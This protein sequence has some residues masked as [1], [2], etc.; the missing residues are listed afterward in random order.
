MGRD[1]SL[2]LVD[3]QPLAVRVAEALWAAGAAEVLAIGGDAE[4]LRAWDLAVRPDDHPGGGPLPATVTALHVA[5]ESIVMV[6][7]CD[8]LAPSADAVAATVHALVA[9]PDVLSA[10][11]VVDG[12]RQWTHAAWRRP[13]GDALEAEWKSGT[14]ALHRAAALLALVEVADLDPLALVDADVPGDLP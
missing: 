5:T 2:L 7:A 13:A 6:M 1:K 14:R 8:L 10:V 3:G 11:P 4:A 12:Y 9:H